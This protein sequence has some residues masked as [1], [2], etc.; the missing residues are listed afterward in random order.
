MEQPRANWTVPERWLPCRPGCY[1]IRPEN[2]QIYIPRKVSSAIFIRL[3]KEKRKCKSM[4]VNICAVGLTNSDDFLACHIWRGRALF[5]WTEMEGCTA[6]TQE[7]E[8]KCGPFPRGEWAMV[9]IYKRM[10][11]E[12]IYGGSKWWNIR[13]GRLSRNK[14]KI[15][16]QPVEVCVYTFLDRQLCYI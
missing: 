7:E 4:V 16:T 2:Y 6:K 13:A 10:R 1:P 9:Y 12:R 14:K 3:A 8:R 11:R 15:N 5:N